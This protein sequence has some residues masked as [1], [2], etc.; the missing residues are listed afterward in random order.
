MKNRMEAHCQTTLASALLSAFRKIAGFRR[1]VGLRVALINYELSFQVLGSAYLGT[2]AWGE[3][4]ASTHKPYLFMGLLI[5]LGY[6]LTFHP[7]TGLA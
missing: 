1:S 3:L 2:S 6:D 7:T 5:T 4:K